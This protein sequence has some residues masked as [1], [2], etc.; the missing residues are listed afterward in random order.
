M[1]RMSETKKRTSITLDTNKGPII[2]D[3]SKFKGKVDLDKKLHELYLSGNFQKLCE[4]FS[5]DCEGC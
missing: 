3:F 5:C 2:L 4:W 1:L